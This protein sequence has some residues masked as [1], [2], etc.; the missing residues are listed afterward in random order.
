[1][2]NTKKYN[3]ALKF[4]YSFCF[5]FAFV[6]NGYCQS[7]CNLSKV[8]IHLTD[9]ESHREIIEKAIRDKFSGYPD[10]KEKLLQFLC[11]CRGRI[12]GSTVPIELING[13][14]LLFASRN[15]N[16][17]L[18]IHDPALIKRAYEEA[19]FMKNMGQGRKT[20]REITQNCAN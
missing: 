19:W 8:S 14:Y 3:V 4:F 6:S 10:L 16:D 18:T 13:Q 12:T 2:N 7:P 9:T 15:T 5:M 17:V 1:M 20:L 11:P